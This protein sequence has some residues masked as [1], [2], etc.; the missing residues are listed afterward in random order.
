MSIGEVIFVS[1]EG[2]GG[3]LEGIY[4]MNFADKFMPD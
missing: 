2:Q 1:A 3:P 4:G